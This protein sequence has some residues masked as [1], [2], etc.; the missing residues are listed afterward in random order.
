[1]AGQE[2]RAVV[3]Q[4]FRDDYGGLLATLIRQ[5]GDFELAEEVLQDAFAIALERWPA[6]GQPDNPAGWIAT[7]ARRRL[8]DRLR[9]RSLREQKHR[10]LETW[11]RSES[12]ES[13]G[14]D[15]EAM[16][17]AADDEPGADD[18]LRLVFTCCHPALDFEARVALTLNT[19][20]GLTA[21]EVARAFLVRERTMAQRLVRAKRKIRGAVI[22]YRVPPPALLPERLP[23][24]LAVVYLIFNEGYAASRGA[25]LVRRELSGEALRLGGLMV[26]LLPDEPEVRGLNALMLLT[27]ARRDARMDAE[28]R[29]VPL[30]EQDRSRWDAAAIAAATAELER[31]LAVGRPGPYQLQAAIAAVHAEA[32]RPQDTDWRQIVLL[33]DELLARRPS[34]VIALNRAVAV[35]MAE[36]PEVGLRAVDRLARAGELDDYLYLHA[37]RADLLRRLSRPADARAAY[38]RAVELCRNESERGYLEG[39]L[40]SLDG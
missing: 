9:R 26:E 10:D 36:G 12:P 4:V 22:P 20:G 5:A 8:I 38:R 18:R 40:A 11:S 24:V 27:D 15:D 28:G 23:A 25:N 6:E 35:A 33:Y 17:S 3:E 13:I 30:E 14:G 39:R 19:L 29:L 32:A 16:I 31:A 37:T 2:A 7:A 21:A 34:P 1:M